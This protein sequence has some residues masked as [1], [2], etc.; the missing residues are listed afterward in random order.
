[1]KNKRSLILIIMLVV[2]SLFTTGCMKKVQ[3]KVG[4]KIGEKIIEKATGGE[5]EMSTKDGLSIETKDGSMKTGE[6]L[7]WPE[8]S[9]KP[10]PK[11][12]AQIISIVELQNDNASSVILKFN[13]KNGADD[14]LQSLIDMGYMQQMKNVMGET[15]MYMGF[16][17]DN[18]QV[19]FQRNSENN[20]GSI[21]LSKDSEAAKKFFEEESDEI[22]EEDYEENYSDSMD[23]P[24]SSMDKIPELKANIV[25]I[26]TNQDSVY[27]GFENVNKDSIIKYIEKIKSLGFDINA[28]EF[29]QKN[30]IIYSAMN[31]KDYSI[32]ISWSDGEGS[33]NY[34][35]Q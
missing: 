11:P 31:D 21:S 16:R 24:K 34:R 17:D 9:M 7:P 30:S 25:S 1:M 12:D 32:S 29:T 15:V 8:D 20:S 22:I 26:S 35:K 19:T 3:E 23:W 28:S 13:K 33:I 2:I 10:L 6:N 14:Y 4:T 5:V 27:V 18:T